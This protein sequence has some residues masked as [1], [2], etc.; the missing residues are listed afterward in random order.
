MS[1]TE[2]TVVGNITGDPELRYTATGTACCVFSVA[3]NQ[4]KFNKLTDKWEDGETSYHR[5][6][7]W[8]YLAENCAESLHK[9]DRVVV[10]GELAERHWSDNEGQ[11]RSA[12]GVTAR[13]IGPDLSYATAKVAKMAR[14][15]RNDVPP[16]DP[17]HSATATRPPGGEN[18]AGGFVDDEPPF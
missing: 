2:I 1:G 3:V 6:T 4:R 18:A 14:T 16:D 8:R 9:G 7:A 5:V 13:A 11:K 10:A 12:W 15:G 17:W